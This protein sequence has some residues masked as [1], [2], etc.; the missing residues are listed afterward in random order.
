MNSPILMQLLNSNSSVAQQQTL[1]EF[2]EYTVMTFSTVHAKI[3]AAH[4]SL[5]A[6]TYSACMCINIS[7]NIC[8]FVLALLV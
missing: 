3:V 5:K 2:A 6:K 1:T 8:I 4:F 7:S